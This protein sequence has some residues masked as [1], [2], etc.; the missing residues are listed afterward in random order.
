MKLKDR[1]FN[2]IKLSPLGPIC[3]KLYQNFD[4]FRWYL[5]YLIGHIPNHTIRIVLYKYIINIKIGSNSSIHR[6]ARFYGPD[7]IVIGNHCVIGPVCFLD[8]RGGIIIGN[9]SVLGGGTWIFTEEHDVNSLTFDVISA[10][11]V[12]EDYVWTGSRALILPGVT[13]GK[14][15]VV[16]AGA[17]V[18]KNVEPYTI[19]GGVPA[20]KIGER[21]KNLKYEPDCRM[22]FC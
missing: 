6:G 18:T 9:N 22:S 14:G 10:P 8:G 4:E 17:V 2:H 15:C 13:L 12:I 19:V 16:A 21:T 1:I 7:K 20:K 3:K 5:A 11:V